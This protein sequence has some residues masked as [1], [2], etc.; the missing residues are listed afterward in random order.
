MWLGSLGL[1]DIKYSG[2][3]SSASTAGSAVGSTVGIAVGS[4]A[5]AVATT[6][7]AIVGAVVA[8]AVA[9][10]TPVGAPLGC[11]VAWPPVV[12]TP[13]PTNNPLIASARANLI[14]AEGLNIIDIHV[15]LLSVQETAWCNYRSTRMLLAYSYVGDASGPPSTE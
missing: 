9:C 11:G 15:F 1:L 3:G 2:A 14:G 7:G 10:G 13:Q 8:T 5:G 12:A 4:A 6:V